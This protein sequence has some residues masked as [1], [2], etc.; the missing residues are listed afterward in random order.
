MNLVKT[1]QQYDINDVIFCEPIKNNIMNDGSFIR[2]LY[3]N[4]KFV[5]N[6]IYLLVSF[7][8]VSI[9]KLYSKY[10]CN[11]KLQENVEICNVL[12]KIE[13]DLL[14]KYI[15]NKI[16]CYKIYEQINMEF[17]KIFME[18]QNI[19]IDTFVLK[20]SGIWE[21]TNNYGLTYKFLQVNKNNIL[22][23]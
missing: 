6:G 3:S 17:I 2:I 8:N 5:L 4:D 13:E 20:I 9:E 23:K 16:P 12:K 10:K 11:F 15:T 18:I 14:K 7:N 1:I 19:D 21:T 22:S